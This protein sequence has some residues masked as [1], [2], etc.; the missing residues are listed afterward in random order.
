MTGAVDG[1]FLSIIIPVLNEAEN[2]G[3]LVASLKTLG[4]SEIIVVDGGSTDDTW[5]QASGADLRLR[6]DRGRARQQNAGAKAASGDVLLFLHADC[7]L[8]PG[9]LETMRG[10]LAEPTVIGG[11]FRQVIDAAGWNYRLVERGNAARVRWL[12]WAYGDQ[13]IFVRKSVFESLG[14]F[15]DLELMED[16]YFVKQLRRSG[17]FA[18]LD[19]PIIVSPRRWQKTGVF[20][21]TLR[22]WTLLTLAHLGVSPDRLAKFYPPVR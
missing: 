2:V 8:Q 3:P 14:G 13:G 6:S 21:Q 7:R 19:V 11:C 1:M 4:D 12:G 10:A 18:P 16:L 5:N 22:N 9:C 20:R 15:P 17:R